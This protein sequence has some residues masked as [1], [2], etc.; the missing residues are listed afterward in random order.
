MSKGGI[1]TDKEREA[2]RADQGHTINP[3]SLLPTEG[4]GGP[5]SEVS[6]QDASRNLLAQKAHGSEELQGRRQE[7]GLGECPRPCSFGLQI[8]S[9]AFPPA[10]SWV[11]EFVCLSS[12]GPPAPLSLE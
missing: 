4:Q 12:S 3:V 11:L 7:P 2:N 9:W 10:S 6:V 1:V 5:H 8:S